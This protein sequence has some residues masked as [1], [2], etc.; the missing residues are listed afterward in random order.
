MDDMTIFNLRTVNKGALRATVLKN[1]T[2][3]AEHMQSGCFT[4]FCQSRFHIMFHLI[5][6]HA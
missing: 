5:G 6:D 1:D 2:S 3:W 4:Q